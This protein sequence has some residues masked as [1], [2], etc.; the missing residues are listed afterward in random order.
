M[1]RAREL[2]SPEDC[3]GQVSKMPFPIRDPMAAS[4]FL[5]HWSCPPV[6]LTCAQCSGPGGSH[7][8]NFYWAMGGCVNAGPCYL[9]PT[10]GLVP[11]SFSASN[12]RDSDRINALVVMC[13]IVACIF[14]NVADICTQATNADVSATSDNKC[15]FS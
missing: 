1:H 7:T 11:F 5:T 13:S 14:R 4:S 6:Y 10:I 9:I 3:S 8:S 2:T 12:E 15:L